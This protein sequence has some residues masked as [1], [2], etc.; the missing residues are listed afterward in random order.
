MRNG[1]ATAKTIRNMKRCLNKQ[2]EKLK[3]TTRM[4]RFKTIWIMQ[5]PKLT[6]HKRTLT[7]QKSQ[8]LKPKKHF[9]KN[10]LMWMLRQ[11]FK[12]NFKAILMKQRFQLIKLNPIL[13]MQK[14]S[15]KRLKITKNRLKRQLTLIQQA[16]RQRSKPW[17]K[18]KLKWKKRKLLKTMLKKR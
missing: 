2:A 16:F 12:N 5:K 15:L 13:K 17:K 4:Q 7:L 3:S 8:K 11:V 10:N 18:H 6:R 9:W 1:T 14:T